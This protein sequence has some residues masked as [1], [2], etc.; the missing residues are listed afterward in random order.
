MRPSPSCKN[1]KLNELCLHALQL[2][3][4]D[5]A[6]VVRAVDNQWKWREAN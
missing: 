6:W 2:V 1:T 3:L 5:K 4:P